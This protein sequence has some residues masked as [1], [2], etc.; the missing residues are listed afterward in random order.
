MNLIAFLDADGFT[1][2]ESASR[3]AAVAEIDSRDFLPRAGRWRQDTDKTYFRGACGI[4]QV[5]VR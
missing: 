2:V 1:V 3:E 4:A 5:A